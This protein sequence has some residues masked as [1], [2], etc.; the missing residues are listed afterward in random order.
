MKYQSKIYLFAA[1]ILL[2]EPLAGLAQNRALSILQ[3]SVNSMGGKDLMNS[4]KTLHYTG[5]GHEYAIEQSERPSGPFLVSY[6]S[7][8]MD[9]DLQAK[10]CLYTLRYKSNSRP[11]QIL[12]DRERTGAISGKNLLPMYPETDEQASLAPEVIA[13]TALL[14]NAIF[15][16]DTILQDVLHRIISFSWK[17]DP[18]RLFV[19]AYTDLVTGVEVVRYYVS[20]FNY[21][22]NRVKRLTLYSYWHMEA[23]G[24]HY[25]YQSDVYVDNRHFRSL[26][27]DSLKFNQPSG[28]DSLTISDSSFAKMQLFA[29][30][31][32][33]LEKSILVPKEIAPAIFF[34]PG[35]WNTSFIK[36]DSGI[37]ILEAPVSAVYSAAVADA[38][39]K[40]YPSE[41]IK[42]VLSTSDAWPHIGG[43]TYYATQK[44]PIYHLDINGAIVRQLLG[45]NGLGDLPKKSARPVL[46]PVTDKT[47]LG[48]GENGM[49]I[50]PMRTETGE[51]IML[52]YFPAKKLLYTSDMLQPGPKG[53][54]FMKQYL[55]EVRDVVR[56][57]RIAVE[58][59]FGM[60]LPL[61]SYELVLKALQ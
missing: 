40:K 55:S 12:V 3:R 1:V 49:V 4:L 36:T 33:P 17:G 39:K 61:T 31:I 54:F 10:K 30:M 9:K 16:K 37:F 43:L 50:Y 35:R 42:G 6:F 53:G 18:V 28:I 58:N 29:K 44:I 34:L 8:Q 59:V 2:V 51:R 48:S 21:V 5:T 46:K 7:M 25:P 41:E 24:L 23:N 19:N 56:R 27:I 60:H 47:Y 52:V 20:N 26:T 14:S 57:E 32:D 15:S 11:Y 45:S 38:V 13:S 22:W